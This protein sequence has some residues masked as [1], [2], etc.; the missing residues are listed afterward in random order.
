MEDMAHA[1]ELNKHKLG[2]FREEKEGLR[3]GAWRTWRK[4][5]GMKIH[6][7]MGKS[8]KMS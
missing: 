2:L 8:R 7:A 6:Q 5:K 3:S 1:K 4:V